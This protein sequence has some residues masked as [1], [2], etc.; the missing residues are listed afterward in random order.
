MLNEIYV[1]ILEDYGWC[2]CDYT[3][4]GRVELAME[5]PAEKNSSYVPMWK[6]SRIL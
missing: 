3:D 4:D 1:D 2:V 6:I 5:S